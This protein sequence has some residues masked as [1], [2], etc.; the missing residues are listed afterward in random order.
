MKMLKMKNISVFL[1]LALVGLM[2][3]TPYFLKDLSNNIFGKFLLVITLAYITIQC[4]FSC[5]VIFAL[6]IIVLLHNTKEGFEEGMKCKKDDE[7]W[8]EKSKKCVPIDDPEK[9]L[10]KKAKKDVAK[11]DKD[12]SKMTNKNKSKAKKA[13]ALDKQ[14]NGD[15]KEPFTGQLISDVTSGLSKSYSNAQD[16][17]KSNII[18]LDREMKTGAEKRSMNATKQ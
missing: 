13:I 6:I 4:E 15:S 1:A 2:Y 12:F 8:D 3:H 7:M 9:K 14:K 5:A 18:D 11:V 16:L 10:V 17:F